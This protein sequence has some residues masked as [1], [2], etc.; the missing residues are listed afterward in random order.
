MVSEPSDAMLVYVADMFEIDSAVESR[1]RAHPRTTVD[2]H[3]DQ[4]V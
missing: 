1:H 4:I 2:R 3:S